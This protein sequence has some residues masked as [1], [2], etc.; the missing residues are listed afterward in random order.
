MNDCVSICITTFALHKF[1]L[2]ELITGFPFVCTT[3]CIF[4]MNCMVFLF[5]GK[6]V[7][8]AVV[9]YYFVSKKSSTVVKS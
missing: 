8:T 5:M 3:T 7:T 9:E 1:L 2:H 4:T 6:N